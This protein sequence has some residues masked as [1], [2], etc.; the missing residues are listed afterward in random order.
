MFLIL[1]MYAV[2]LL[3]KIPMTTVL[4]SLPTTVTSRTCNQMSLI[5]SSQDS[6][7][8]KM[9]GRASTGRHNFHTLSTYIRISDPRTD[10]RSM[11]KWHSNHTHVKPSPHLHYKRM[12]D[13][14]QCLQVIRTPPAQFESFPGQL[15]YALADV[16]IHV[17]PTPSR[18]TIF[19][20]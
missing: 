4:N 10:M 7:T 9:F 5:V 17:P 14:P 12:R 16:P 6:L 18:T 8:T 19:Q 2:Q 1:T 20:E 11:N 3:I 13:R 15:V